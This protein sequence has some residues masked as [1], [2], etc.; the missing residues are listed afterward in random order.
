MRKYQQLTFVLL[1][2]L[3]SC[4]GQA[5]K[6]PNTDSTSITTIKTDTQAHPKK[7]WVDTLITD[8]YPVT[9]DMLD[10]Q[11]GT[12]SYTKKSGTLVSSD[13]AWFRNDRLG[14][15]LVIELYTDHFRVASYHFLN[16][17]IPSYIIERMELQNNAGEMASVAEK[18]RYFKGFIAQGV[19]TDA[20]YFRTN[21]WMLLGDTLPKAIKLYG[22]PDKRSS[23]G[24][25]DQLEWNF[26]GD[27]LYD[28]KS[29]L[30][31]K[32]VVK[33]NFGHQVVLFF[34]KGKLIAQVLI[35]DI[36]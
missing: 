23:K 16:Q 36:P 3:Y 20:S 24:G 12:G 30:K 13:K 10:A 27:K 18:K 19:P 35:N 1:I 26:V 7:G 15:T 17:D 9:I 21:K 32:P 29:D 31:G 4:T 28:G 8:E 11:K 5:G 6:T 34:R 2:G 33:D 25:I 22:E 14:Q